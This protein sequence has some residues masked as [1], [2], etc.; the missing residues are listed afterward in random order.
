MGKR[1]ERNK[2][3]IPQEKRMRRGKKLSI[4]ARSLA[5][6]QYFSRVGRVTLWDLIP[7]F[8]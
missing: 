1:A 6:V 5:Y 7:S 8:P 4:C 2:K 3:I